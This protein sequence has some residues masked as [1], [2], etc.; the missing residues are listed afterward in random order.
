LLG[1]MPFCTHCGVRP[2]VIDPRCFPSHPSD[3]RIHSFTESLGKRNNFVPWCVN[4]RSDT[5]T[6]PTEEMRTAMMEADLGDE[7]A[8]TDP[9]V[10]RLEQMGAELLGKEAAL[11]VVS[12]TMG[13]LV[14]VMSHCTE[15]SSQVFVGDQSHNFLWEQG[16]VSTLGGIHQRPIRNLPDGTIDLEELETAI[17]VYQDLKDPHYARQKLV[18]LENTHNRCGGQALPPSYVDAAGAL[19]KKYGLKLHIDGARLFNACTKYNVPPAR[20]VQGADS[21]S[22]CFSKGLCAPVGGLVIGSK[23]FIEEARRSRKALGGALRQS[24]VIASTGI[25]ALTHMRFRLQE[26]HDNALW[27]AG[28]LHQFPGLVLDSQL[29]KAQTNQVLATVDRAVL[30]VNAIE[31]AE[32][33]GKEGVYIN[34]WTPSVL[35]FVLHNDAQ[36]PALKE[37]VKRMRAVCEHLLRSKSRL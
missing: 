28:E 30:G 14:S 27:L 5:G 15:R 29:I 12:G 9:T 32:L 8:G 18:V 36:L 4:L 3:S 21:I 7:Q 25:L 2:P 13:N 31:L 10:L 22:I 16:N 24:G 33:W 37:A 6:L 35:R 19:C 11:Y 1:G 20:M 17:T 23:A 26:D 34:W